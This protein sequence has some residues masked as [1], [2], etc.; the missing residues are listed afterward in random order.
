M[1]QRRKFLAQLLNSTSSANL[2]FTALVN[3]LVFLGFE[4]RIRGSHHIFTHSEVEEII[5][6]QPA[7][8]NTVKPYQAKQ[9]R[10]LIIHYDLASHFRDTL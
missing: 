6:L 2:D 4:L 3:L 5:N 1:S 8:G 10:E 9:V 7:T